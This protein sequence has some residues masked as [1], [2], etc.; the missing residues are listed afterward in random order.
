VQ[1]LGGTLEREEQRAGV[2]VLD[3]VDAELDGGHDA[4]VPAAAAQ[5]PEQVR[6]VIRVRADELAGAIHL[7]AA[8]A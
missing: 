6:M 2:Q 4:E 8:A 5:R 1:D 7:A 3:L